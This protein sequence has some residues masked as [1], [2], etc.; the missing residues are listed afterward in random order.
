[1]NE[2]TIFYC[3]ASLVYLKEKYKSNLAFARAEQTEDESEY[4]E[5]C[6]REI[7]EAIKEI[8]TYTD[9]IKCQ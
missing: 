7:T 9:V 6:I 4:W 2:K 5:K 8:S 1:M 3:T